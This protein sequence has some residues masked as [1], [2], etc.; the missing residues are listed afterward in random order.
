MPNYCNCHPIECHD[1]IHLLF[2]YSIRP[3]CSILLDLQTA[4]STIHLNKIHLVH[5]AFHNAIQFH[6]TR[7]LALLVQRF[8]QRY[9]HAL[10]ASSYTD[11]RRPTDSILIP[12]KCTARRRKNRNLKP[13]APVVGLIGTTFKPGARP[14]VRPL[15]RRV[16]YFT[17][18][19]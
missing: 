7:W 2:R 3:V 8:F 5:H 10:P 15:A 13:L 9:I 1:I 19:L 6:G 16:Y 11:T 4:V 18:T 14:V 12:S 17:S